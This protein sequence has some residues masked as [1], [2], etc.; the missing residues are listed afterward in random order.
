MTKKVVLKIKLT[1]VE[2]RSDRNIGIYIW[3]TFY[4]DAKT[5]Q[6]VHEP[7]K[8][9]QENLPTKNCVL[10][11][12]LTMEPSEVQPI[13]HDQSANVNNVKISDLVEFLVIFFFCSLCFH[14]KIICGVGVHFLKDARLRKYPWWIFFLIGILIEFSGRSFFPFLPVT[15]QKHTWMATFL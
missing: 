9:I 13:S 14:P 15:L 1:I 8:A 4:H 6:V 11:H 12:W 2:Y 10:Q 5:L 3:S 7:N